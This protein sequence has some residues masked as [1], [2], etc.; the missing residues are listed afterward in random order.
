[1]CLYHTGKLPRYIRI[2]RKLYNI[3]SND[4]INL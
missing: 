4:V 3:K 2:R 1:M